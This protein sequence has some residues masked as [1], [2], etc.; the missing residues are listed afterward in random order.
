MISPAAGPICGYTTLSAPT[1]L[2]APLSAAGR[3]PARQHSRHSPIL[4]P[5]IALILPHTISHFYAPPRKANRW[6]MGIR[7]YQNTY[8]AEQAIPCPSYG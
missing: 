3:F 2:Y 6:P 8:S 5:F 4:A 1:L 7:L